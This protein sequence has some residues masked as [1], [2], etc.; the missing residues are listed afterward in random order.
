MNIYTLQREQFI[1]K[2]VDEVF[3]FF[4]DARNLEV[5]TPAWLKSHIL[6]TETI[7]MRIGTRI[8]YAL[9]W[10]GIPL[11]WITEIEE[12]NPPHRFIDVQIKGPYKLW[13]YTHQFLPAGQG[14]HML[15]RVEYSLPFAP[16]ARVLH[17]AWIRRDLDAIFDYRAI[18]IHSF[19]LSTP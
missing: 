5:I 15:D 6:T 3:N 10:H 16:L 17:H 12:W 13:R 14:T 1:A 4:S 2:P 7:H 9:R 11:K 19:S 18:R 8:R